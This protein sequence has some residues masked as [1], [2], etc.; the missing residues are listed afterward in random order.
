VRR[1]A[2]RIRDWSVWVDGR[3]TR[4]TRDESANEL[5]STQ[6]N[7]TA[8]ISRKL[9]PDM[10]IGVIAG[11]RISVT[12]CRASTAISKANGW[13]L[14]VYG[15]WRLVPQVRVDGA[16]AWSN[17][18][19]NGNRRCIEL[20]AVINGTSTG[21]VTVQPLARS[22]SVCGRDSSH[23]VASS[24]SHPRAFMCWGSDRPRGPT[25][26]GSRQA[27]RQFYIGRASV[28]GKLVLSLAGNSGPQHHALMPA[29]TATIAFQG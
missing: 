2:H 16:V 26:S 29:S 18:N 17:V 13:T 15:A 8:G 10:L 21:A 4:W 3:G 24:S 20:A 9:T 22:P 1:C 12:T 14:G 27:A 23:R 7:V 28:G 25:A 19:Y 5:R 11:M 6:L